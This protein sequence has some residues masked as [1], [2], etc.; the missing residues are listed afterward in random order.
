MTSHSQNPNPYARPSNPSRKSL[1]LI[2]ILALVALGG[3][4]S[5]LLIRLFI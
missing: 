5:S 1:T 2:Q 3:L 4:T